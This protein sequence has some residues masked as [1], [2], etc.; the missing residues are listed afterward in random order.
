MPGS[1]DMSEIALGWSTYGGDHM[2]I[3]NVNAG[4]P[5]TVIKRMISDIAVCDLVSEKLQNALKNVLEAPISP[6]LLPLDSNGE[7]SQNTEESI[8]AY[9]LHDFFLYYKLKYIMEDKLILERAKSAFFGIYAEEYIEKIFEIFK[10]RFKSQ[11]FKRKGAP[12]GL[13]LCDI[14]FFDMPSDMK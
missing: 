14:N 4:L 10:K 2:A 6:E 11:E 13:S 9:E 12:E 1:G 7:V 5:K 3:Y 8:G